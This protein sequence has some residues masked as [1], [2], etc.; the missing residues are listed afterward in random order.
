MEITLNGK[1][2][3]IN[4]G[5]TLMELV[6]SK[7]LEPERVVAEYN[8]KIINREEWTEITLKENDNLELLRFVGGG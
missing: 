6:L 1:K 2:I 3:M 8:G 5:L 7:H 4:D